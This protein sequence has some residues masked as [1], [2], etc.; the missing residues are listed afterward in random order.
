MPWP[1][2]RHCC[3]EWPDISGPTLHTVSQTHFARVGVKDH[4]D[5]CG[6]PVWNETGFKILRLMRLAKLL[7]LA[8]IKRLLQ[9]YEDSVFDVTPFLGP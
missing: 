3:L 8:R 5:E 2:G 6:G 7:R 9:K 4:I 1:H